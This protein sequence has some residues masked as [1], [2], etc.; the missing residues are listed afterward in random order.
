VALLQMRLEQKTT[1]CADFAKAMHKTKAEFGKRQVNIY[2]YLYIYI[3]MYPPHGPCGTGLFFTWPDS[4]ARNTTP[5]S[6]FLMGV[7]ALT[8]TASSL[9]FSPCSSGPVAA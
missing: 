7:Y 8:P 5:H 9:A 3:Y 1:V 6:C 2:L 4:H